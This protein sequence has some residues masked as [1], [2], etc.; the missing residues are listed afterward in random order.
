MNIHAARP[1]IST[2]ALQVRGGVCG[3]ARSRS[4]GRVVHLEREA[5]TD[6]MAGDA[7]LEAAGFRQ[8]H[9]D[10]RRLNIIHPQD[11]DSSGHSAASTCYAARGAA[12]AGSL[13]LVTNEEV[14]Y[15]GHASVLRQIVNGIHMDRAHNDYTYVPPSKPQQ[16]SSPCVY[17]NGLL[18]AAFVRGERVTWWW[19]AEPTVPDAKR[20]GARLIDTWNPPWNRARPV[21]W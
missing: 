7:E 14:R 18:N 16:T 15:I 4:C 21:V 19:R 1:A 9:V 2:R 6:A 12:P 13:C 17:V 20:L 3:G 5:R 10:G 11:T 8:H